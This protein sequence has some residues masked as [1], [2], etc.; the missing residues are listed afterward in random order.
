MIVTE[1]IINTE[2]RKES[3][4]VWSSYFTSGYT[5]TFMYRSYGNHIMISVKEMLHYFL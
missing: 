1:S 5:E 4:E 2:S 3:Y